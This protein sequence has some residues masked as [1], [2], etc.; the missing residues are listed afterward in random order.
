[1]AD[2][3]ARVAQLTHLASGRIEDMQVINYQRG[4]FYQ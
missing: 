4:G 1:M 2:V 3:E